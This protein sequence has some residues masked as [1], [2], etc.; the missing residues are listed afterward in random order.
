V[1]YTVTVNIPNQAKGSDVSVPDLGML[2]KNGSTHTVELDKD[3]AAKLNRSYGITAKKKSSDN[4]KSDKPKRTP[5]A[6]RKPV[7]HA[8]VTDQNKFTNT[9]T[10]TLTKGGES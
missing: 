1:K 2:V 7:Q 9:S 6:R 4:P 8:N 5:S 3:T 10:S